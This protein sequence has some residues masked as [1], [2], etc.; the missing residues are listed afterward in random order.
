M[1]TLRTF[2]TILKSDNYFDC[3]FAF[4]YTKTFRKRCSLSK[5]RIPSHP[6]SGLTW[7]H[8]HFPQEASISTF[9]DIDYTLKFILVVDKGPYGFLAQLITWGYVRWRHELL[10]SFDRP[11][12]ALLD[13]KIC[14]FCVIKYGLH[15]VYLLIQYDA[16]FHGT[17]NDMY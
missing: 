6:W 2:S 11:L 7:K 17:R 14:S 1:D 16:I 13:V 12:Y 4:T 9:W 3:L 8:I 10:C 5:K 15:Y